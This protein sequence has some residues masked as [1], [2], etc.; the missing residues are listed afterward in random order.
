LACGAATNAED[1]FV[2]SGEAGDVPDDEEIVG[3]LG[4]LDDVQLV[5]KP[6]LV[7][8]RRP[9]RVALPETLP[10]ELPKVCIRVLAR[11]HLVFRQMQRR[12]IQCH[13]CGISNLLGV[14]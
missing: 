2:F 8:I 4:R 14:L 10:A 5:L 3:I 11:G 7:G 9:L 12:E 1:D 13:I 6:L